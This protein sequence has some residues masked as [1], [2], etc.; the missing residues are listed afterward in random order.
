MA[1]V[2][3][4]DARGRRR[5]SATRRLMK[6]AL[7]IRSPAHVRQ[8]LPIAHA[9]PHHSLRYR[10][11]NNRQPFTVTGRSLRDCP[12][13]RRPGP[14]LLSERV[15]GTEPEERT[16]S[17]G[18]E[19]KVTEPPRLTVGVFGQNVS[20]GA[21]RR[22]PYSPLIH[23]NNPGNPHGVPAHRAGAQLTSRWSARIDLP[24]RAAN[25]C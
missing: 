17:G 23:P 5:H 1:A 11:H 14:E 16:R 6:H 8:R 10:S 9:Q 13:V 12:P 18:V 15:R 3:L 24:E 21:E 7:S 25:R 19:I 22:A 20:S 4:V 2:P